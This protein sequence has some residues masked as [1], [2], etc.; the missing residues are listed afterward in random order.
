MIHVAVLINLAIL[1]IG[2][3]VGG[4]LY[5]A[6]RTNP[7]PA[8]L[9][10]LFHFTAL[11]FTMG[12]AVLAAYNIANLGFGPFISR[13]VSALV[14]I[15]VGILLFTFAGWSRAKAGLDRGR[16]FCFFWG[17]LAAIPL[18]AAIYT[19][20]GSNMILVSI[21]ICLSFVPFFSSVLYGLNVARP[22]AGPADRR[23]G[24][25]PVRSAARSAAWLNEGWVAFFLL[26]LVAAAEVG[27]IVMHP[28]QEQHVFVT[29][30]LAY[31]YVCRSAWKERANADLGGG[32]GA[33][34]LGIPDAM[35]AEKGLTE[36]ELRM[37]EGILAGKSNK[38][39]AYELG[40]AE[41]TVRNHIY[42]LYRKL[43]I[44]KR[45]DLVLLVQKYQA[46]QGQI[47]RNLP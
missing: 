22:S 44:Q 41:N 24:R 15:G 27:W 21:L 1:L 33:P 47:G 17:G 19:L 14:L 23:A 42:N 20:T 32:Q 37:A 34:G 45:I 3:G 46:V 5:R 35:V 13:V 25:P 18:A 39:L 10:Q 9:W 31:L 38:E 30:P 12:A 6:Y 43:E 29:L 28:Q 40:I 4:G 2:V 8:A 36:R 11:T 16:G 7:S 26:A